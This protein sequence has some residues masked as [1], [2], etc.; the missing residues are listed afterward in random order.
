M[1]SKQARQETVEKKR[2]DVIRIDTAVDM[3]INDWGPREYMDT[4]YHGP[5]DFEE[6]WFYGQKQIP[7][8]LGGNQYYGP[9]PENNW[10]GLMI[11]PTAIPDKDL[12]DAIDQI[13]NIVDKRTLK[14][15]LKHP[16]FYN[17]K[18]IAGE[19]KQIKQRDTY[20]ETHQK[21]KETIERA[22]TYKIPTPKTKQIY[23]WDEA[24]QQA[25]LAFPI[26]S[27]K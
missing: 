16:I 27:R 1:F 9:A 5:M 6:N 11:R 18:T 4:K 24:A 8:W 7:A 17:F 3:K 19:R 21:I 15:A 25:G 10:K 14:N 22:R 13:K 2:N 12:L 26:S 23:P 20:A